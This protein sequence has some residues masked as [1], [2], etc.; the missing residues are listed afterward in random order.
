M[1][2]DKPADM[3]VKPDAVFFNKKTEAFIT[4]KLQQFRYVVVRFNIRRI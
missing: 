1:D 2:Y 3:P 4:V